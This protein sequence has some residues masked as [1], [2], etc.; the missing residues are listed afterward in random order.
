M[1]GPAERLAII[2]LD[3]GI[4]ILAPRP[5]RS[6]DRWGASGGEGVHMIKQQ[7]SLVGEAP[8]VRRAPAAEQYERYVGGTPGVERAI[9]DKL[10][11][12]L[13]RV[14]LKIKKRSGAA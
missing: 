4:K 14:Q 2:S 11:R 5:N 12:D 7:E 1:N 6:H 13:M 3:H 8:A 9:F 10:A